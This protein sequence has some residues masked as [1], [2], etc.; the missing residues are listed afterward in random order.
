MRSISI[1]DFNSLQINFALF[2]FDQ[3]PTDDPDILNMVKSRFACEHASS[4][5][6]RKS[7][8]RSHSPNTISIAPKMAVASGSMWPFVMKSI[9]C[10]WLKAVGRILQR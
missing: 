6:Y 1:D 7:D 5:E 2:H 9:A 3:Q 4:Q 8:H 10:K